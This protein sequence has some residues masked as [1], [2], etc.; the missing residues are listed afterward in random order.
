[1]ATAPCPSPGPS[2]RPAP[3]ACAWRRWTRRWPCARRAS[4]VPDPG[5]VSGPAGR[6]RRWRPTSGIAVAA[7]DCRAL[8]RT[9]AAL[10]DRPVDEPAPGP[11]SWRSR[12][13]WAAA[14]SARRESCDLA[15]AI[16]AAPAVRLGRAVDPPPGDR[17]CRPSTAEQLGPLR[18]RRART[19]GRPAS[20]SPV[21]ARRGQRRG[22][23]RCRR[24]RRHPPGPVH[25]RH[26]ARRIRAGRRWRRTAIGR[27][28][29]R[30]WPSRPSRCGSPTC[31]PAMASATARPS[32]PTRPSRIATLPARL[33]RRLQPAATP[34]PPRS[35]CAGGA[36]RSS[37]T[38]PWTRVMVD[39]TDVPGRAGHHRR[40]IRAPG[41]AR[42]TTEIDVAELARRRTTNTW[43]VVTQMAARLPRVYHAASAPVGVADPHRAERRVARIE[44]WNGDICD[45][46][47]DAIVNP[48]NLSLWM[49][50]GVGGAIKRAG[51]DAIEFAA[52]RQAPVPLGGAIVTTGRHARRPGR[53]PRRLARPRPAHQRPDHRGGRAQRDGPGPRDRGHE[54]RLPGPRHGRRRVPARGGRADHRRRPCATS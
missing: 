39:V 13:A 9:L 1:M 45:L 3:T 53:H 8:A 43:E 20:R 40:R 10:A 31:R 32:G 19:C 25:L 50:T 21:R 35:S 49:A 18:R 2:R 15:R 23:D 26:R 14:G 17:G 7:G 41:R 4:R 30:S 12:P 5:P 28:C 47:V 42:G 37:A 38:W 44:L 24:P 54:H 16:A 33:W 34:T 46:E 51:G 36:C 6:W 29:G 52:V 27:G 48:A 22:P 11:A